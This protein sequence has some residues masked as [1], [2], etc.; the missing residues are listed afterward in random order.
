MSIEVSNKV[1][2]LIRTQ[3]ASGRFTSEDELLFEALQSLAAEDEELRA[4]EEGLASFD[5][6]EPGI[7]LADA[8]EQLRK[9]HSL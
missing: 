5:R 1:A 8:F 2:E 4:I 7:P 6:G 3:M 9:K